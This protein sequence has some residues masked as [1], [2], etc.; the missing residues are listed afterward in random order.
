MGVLASEG[1]RTWTAPTVA[2]GSRWWGSAARGG[3]RR[4]TGATLC[5]A[6][7]CPAR[8]ASGGD[9]A[10]RRD[11]S[12]YSRAAYAG[13][14]DACDSFFALCFFLCGRGLAAAA[15][16]HALGVRY[17]TMCSTCVGLVLCL[18]SL[19]F[20]V[21]P[22]LSSL[23]TVPR[24]NTLLVSA[25]YRSSQ[26]HPAAST[27]RRAEGARASAPPPFTQNGAVKSLR[28]S[29]G[30][31]ASRAAGAK[32]NSQPPFPAS[33]DGLLAPPRRRAASSPSRPC[34]RAPPTR[35]TAAWPAAPRAPP[36]QPRWSALAFSRG[37]SVLFSLA[38]VVNPS[39]LHP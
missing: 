12:F 28:L 16:Q 39:M 34:T 20:G 15:V 1:W 35:R 13:P 7:G 8:A 38:G 36:V 17:G 37:S 14:S 19:L 11:C 33:S 24:A 3:G 31:A 27:W 26:A 32:A 4:V 29:A 5:G 21:D 9:A 25:Y 23:P 22:L 18:W 30:D 6:E 2:A 10:R